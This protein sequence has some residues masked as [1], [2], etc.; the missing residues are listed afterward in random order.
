MNTVQNDELIGITNELKLEDVN[1]ANCSKINTEMFII[2]R[3]NECY[4]V[5]LQT[6]KI[7]QTVKISI[8]RVH[9]LSKGLISFTVKRAG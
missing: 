7:V 2:V 3:V 1:S 4:I 5:D 9:Y 6:L 8:K